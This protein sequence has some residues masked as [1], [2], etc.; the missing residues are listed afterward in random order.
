M[1]STVYFQDFE[2]ELACIVDNTA[3]PVIL[4]AGDSSYNHKIP[5]EYYKNWSTKSTECDIAI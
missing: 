1:F 5:A 2:F 4:T 3:E